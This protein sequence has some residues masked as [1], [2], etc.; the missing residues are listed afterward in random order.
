MELESA[1]DGGYLLLSYLAVSVGSLVVEVDSEHPVLLDFGVHVAVEEHLFAVSPVGNDLHFLGDSGFLSE[2]ETNGS[3]H[4]LL[5]TLLPGS[6]KHGGVSDG[7]LGQGEGLVVSKGS[8][9]VFVGE[10]TPDSGVL[11]DV[12]LTFKSEG[13]ER[14]VGEVVFTSDS[15]RN[16][17]VNDP[18]LVEDF[19]GVVGPEFLERGS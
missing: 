13:F 1:I 19:H 10:M 6:G 3:F 17:S 5:N 2:S 4:E 7:D 12:V 11:V 9:F 14:L 8:E 16:I 15:S 18:H